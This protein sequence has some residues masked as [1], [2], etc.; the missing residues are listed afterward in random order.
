MVYGDKCGAR[1]DSD[2]RSAVTEQRATRASAQA[3]V[4]SA[5]RAEYWIVDLDARLIERWLA[6]ESRA[7][8]ID[9]M[10]ELAPKGATRHFVLG[11]PAYFRSIYGEN[12]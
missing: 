5:Q 9:S 3:S 4:V 2:R 10:L 11:V 8:C 6:G 12:D 7:E 1:S